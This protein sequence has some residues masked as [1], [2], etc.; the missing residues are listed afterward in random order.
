M[1]PPKPSRKR[2]RTP[3]GLVPAE[4]V[5]HVAPGSRVVRRADGEGFDVV[6]SDQAGEGGSDDG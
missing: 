5:R 6:R 1:T 4:N 2:V 3:A